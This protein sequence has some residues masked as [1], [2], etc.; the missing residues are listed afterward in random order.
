MFQKWCG[1]IKNETG[2]NCQNAW[3]TV[4]CFL[5]RYSKLFG[6]TIKTISKDLESKNA[7]YL[8]MGGFIDQLTAGVYNWLP[9]GL[10]VLRKVEQIVRE[11]MDELG[12]QEIFMPSLHPKEIWKK[13]GRWENVD[14]LFKIKSQTDKEYALGC[15]HEEVV[16]P[17]AQRI[18]RS[19]KELPFAVYQINTK[20]RDE[21]RAK[22]GVLRGREFRM[23][24]MYSFHTNQ[25][26]LDAFYARAL[27]A[28]VKAFARCGVSVKVVQASGGIFTDKISHEFQMLTDAGED[29]LIACEKCSFGQNSEVATYKEGGTC[30][31]C[32]SKIVKAKGIEVGNIFDLGTKYTDA[33]GFD[34]TNEQGKKQP[35][36]MGCY[37]LGTSRLVGAVVEAHHDENGIKWPASIAPF[38]LHMIDLKSKDASV[39]ETA[40]KI[41]ETLSEQGVDILFDD[42]EDTA[43]G[44][45]FADADL[46]GI[47]KRMVVSEKTLKEGEVEFRDRETGSTAM[48]K[49]ENLGKYLHEYFHAECDCK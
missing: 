48:V 12:A 30:P 22:S 7:Q 20:F 11:E 31:K 49:I 40:A 34:I 19:Y 1:R 41:Y 5:M 15:S 14:I 43:A 29:T 46:I 10:S 16:T 42:R 17:L 21:L 33:F 13:T 28:Y 35:V 18:T 32:G 2:G 8:T 44:A 23:K 3:E 25:A 45:K 36:L 26:D 38:D 24:D 4:G 9:L 37:G 39:R 27:D 47:P 6:K